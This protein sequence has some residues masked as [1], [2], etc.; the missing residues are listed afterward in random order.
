MVTSQQLN[1]VAVGFL[2]EKEARQPFVVA[3]EL[4]HRCTGVALAYQRRVRGAHIGTDHAD[5]AVARAVA[6]GFGAALVLAQLDLDIV[7]G[8]AQLD[9]RKVQ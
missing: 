5:V 6:V 1:L 8:V 3:L 9:Q 4:L 2:N 7:L